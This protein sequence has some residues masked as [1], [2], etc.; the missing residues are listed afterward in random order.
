M[1][2]IGIYKSCTGL[3]EGGG[4]LIGKDGERGIEN[5]DCLDE[6]GNI[7]CKTISFEAQRFQQQ[8]RQHRS[9]L[10]C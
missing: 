10:K 5:D 6:G 7:C 9:K 4:D 1:A 2:D 8:H 3:V